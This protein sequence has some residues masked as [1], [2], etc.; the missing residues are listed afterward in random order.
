MPARLRTQKIRAEAGHLQRG[1]RRPRR[2]YLAQEA[3]RSHCQ[4]SLHA[5]RSPG[6]ASDQHVSQGGQASQGS[7]RLPAIAELQL[8]TPLLPRKTVQATPGCIQHLLSGRID[9]S[10]ASDGSARCPTTD[11]GGHL[12]AETAEPQ[13]GAQ[14]KDDAKLTSATVDTKVT[15]LVSGGQKE[16]HSME[17]G[18]LVAEQETGACHHMPQASARDAC[19]C[20]IFSPRRADPML[21]GRLQVGGASDYVRDREWEDGRVQTGGVG[22]GRGR[23]WN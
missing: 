16:A 17:D 18:D 12:V 15:E 13:R 23:G 4:G 7:R 9:M 2:K 14:A 20:L 6:G 11:G 21:H 1:T 19:A 5:Q 10:H 22:E 8:P 3:R